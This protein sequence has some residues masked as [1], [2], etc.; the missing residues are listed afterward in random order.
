MATKNKAKTLVFGND[1]IEV[2]FKT[3]HGGLVSAASMAVVTRAQSAIKK[4]RGLDALLTAIT[5]FVDKSNEQGFMEAAKKAVE[6]GRLTFTEM[7]R[8]QVSDDKLE[9]TDGEYFAV[10]LKAYC[11]VLTGCLDTV[12]MGVDVLPDFAES[13]TWEDI[14]AAV[15]DFFIYVEKK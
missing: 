13:Q 2:K 15:E 12:A 6:A 14:K 1:R 8:L 7:Q 3:A 9:A 5:P 4:A 10:K 11:D